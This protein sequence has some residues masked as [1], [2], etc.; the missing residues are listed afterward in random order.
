MRQRKTLGFLVVRLAFYRSRSPWPSPCSVAV[1]AAA[2]PLPPLA[3]PLALP[4]TPAP[5]P[6]L[7]R[8][9]RRHLRQ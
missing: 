4:R 7:R 8:Y 9:F 5:P 6:P 1:L 3:S 2:P